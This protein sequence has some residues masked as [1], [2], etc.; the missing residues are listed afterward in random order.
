MEYMLKPSKYWIDRLI[1]AYMARFSD[2][3]LIRLNDTSDSVQY[4]L[5]ALCN[6]LTRAVAKWPLSP[7]RPK[8]HTIIIIWWSEFFVECW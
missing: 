4:L 3:G 5:V 1:A 6:I 2:E 7:R 8:T